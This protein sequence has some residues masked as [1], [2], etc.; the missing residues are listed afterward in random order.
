MSGSFKP[1]KTNY[2]AV[3]N[4]HDEILYLR[5][6]LNRL[7]IDNEHYKAKT[8]EIKAKISSITELNCSLQEGL[9]AERVSQ[10]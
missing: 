10:R 7:R 5:N 8:L 6:E 1:S 3:E 9:K 2:V 4:L